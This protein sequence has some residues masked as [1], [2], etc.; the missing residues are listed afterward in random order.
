MWKN[1]KEGIKWEG[2]VKAKK[3]NGDIYWTQTIIHP[4]YIND[5]IISYTAIKHDITEKKKLETL[6]ITDD[7]TGLFSRRHFN[8]III[9]EISRVKRNDNYLS[10]LLMDID[11]FKNYNDTYGHILG[12]ETLKKVTSVLK[13][14]T[15]RSC[16]FAFRVGGEEF[17]LI[18]SADN[19]EKSLAFCNT[20]KE[21]IQK[22]GI[23]H[24]ASDINEFVTV[25]IG[26]VVKRGSKIK[27][28]KDLYMK[29]DDAL[30]KAKELGRNRVQL[31]I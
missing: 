4:E 22:L 6:S 14:Y 21:N 20:L 5:E 29:A 12:D 3:K 2:E 9:D 23:E 17:C 15:K 8:K 11:Y 31:S 28:S 27:D 24:K 25:S 1:L 30:Y 7:L 13:K 16:D 19:E 18:F 26:L 10:F